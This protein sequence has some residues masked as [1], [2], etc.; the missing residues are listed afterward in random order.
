MT[1]MVPRRDERS[2]VEP[3][4]WIRRM[5]GYGTGRGRRLPDRLIQLQAEFPN[6]RSGIIC[7]LLD[8]VMEFPWGGG[9]GDRSRLLDQQSIFRRVDDLAYP[10]I[11]EID[12]RLRSARSRAYAEPGISYQRNTILL[13]SGNLGHRCQ[14]FG[15]GDREN[16]DLLAL[17][18][19]HD[20][21]RWRDIEMTS[22]G[23]DFPKDFG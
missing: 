3:R 11:E 12:D 16:L 13:E 19:R 18:R 8:H 4:I 14:P 15:A 6:D 2:K 17:I 20:R 5:R 7:R 23:N 10:L 1:R 22:T 9:D 21:E